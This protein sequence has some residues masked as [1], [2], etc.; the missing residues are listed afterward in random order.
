MP[1]EAYDLC[2]KEF[3]DIGLLVNAEKCKL[4]LPN[5]EV[6]PF[7]SFSGIA[8]VPA[9][10]G[11]EVLGVPIGSESFVAGTL[12]SKLEELESLLSRLAMH[13]SSLAKF[14]LL[15]ACLGTC[16][17]VFL[18]RSVPFALGKTLAD[19]TAVLIRKSLEA[20]LHNVQLVDAKRNGGA[21]LEALAA[22]SSAMA[23]GHFG[24]DCMQLFTAARL[25]ALP[26]KG[27]GVRPVAVWDT[28]RRL[29]AKCAL[30]GVIEQIVRCLLPS[31]SVQ[32][33]RAAFEEEPA[34]G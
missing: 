26:K 32:R 13:E 23:N 16:R 15:R 21:L 30:E 12:Q 25:V 29:V 1:Q 28:L 8:R 11:V 9:T 19:K 14:L 6:I 2:R 17:K 31:P 27:D 22:F 20:L 3:D 24:Q 18:L 5:S 7:E 10:H 33:G 34:L 4:F